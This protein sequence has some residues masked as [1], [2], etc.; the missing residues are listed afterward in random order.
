MR[1]HWATRYAS[2]PQHQSLL[3]QLTQWF[4]GNLAKEERKKADWS[5]DL[6]LL[7]LRISVTLKPFSLESFFFV[8]R[9]LCPQTT[10][11]QP[12]LTASFLS[13]FS[14]SAQPWGLLL[15]TQCQNIWE[16]V[17]AQHQLEVE[18]SRRRE[19]ERTRDRRKEEKAREGEAAPLQTP[20]RMHKLYL[21]PQLQGRF[22]PPCEAL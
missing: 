17:E 3:L 8:F 13:H 9:S 15:L 4:T 7:A 22:R 20:R 5:F 11:H 10:T 1:V 2:Y 6:F 12:N 21:I 16:E 14:S 19:R 18:S